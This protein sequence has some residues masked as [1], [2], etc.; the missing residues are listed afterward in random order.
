MRTDIH[1]PKSLVTEDYEY[2]GAFDN[3]EHFGHY[4]LIFLQRSLELRQ[5]LA[6]SKTAQYGNGAQ[7]DHCGAHIRYV[8]VLRH[9]P[10]GDH[11]AVG[12][13]CLDNRFPLS[14]QEFH[15]LRKAAELD[16]QA[17]K[18]QLDW[19]AYIAEHS[20]VDW[21]ALF[22]SSNSFVQDVLR[23]GARYGNLSQRQLDAI[24]GAVER[25]GQRAERQ[26]AEALEPK[27][28]VPDTDARILVEAELLHKKW[29]DNQFGGGFKGLLKVTTT[30]GSYKLWGNLPKAVTQAEQGAR[31]R[32]EAKVVRSDKDESFGFWSNPRKA[33]VLP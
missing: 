1:A 26:A 17:H 28:A 4:N 12:E 14:T 15:R 32:F 29:E 22:D 13:V 16:R 27:V 21:V 5:L 33:V 10:T 19:A 30:A 7:C 23:K 2:V 18:I 20:E 25:D 8:G 9:I 11:I 24:V 31:I 3:G 6:G